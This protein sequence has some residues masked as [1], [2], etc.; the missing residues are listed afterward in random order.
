[1][2]Y[3]FILF[4]LS[5]LLISCNNKDSY[6]KEFGQFMNDTENVGEDYSD[7]E[8]AQIEIKFN[9]LYLRKFEEYKEDLTENDIKQIKKFK[10]RFTIIQV[11]REPLKNILKIIGL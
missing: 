1:M 3:L 5:V 6:I 7:Q 11:N 8:W 10:D 4:L 2:K 9:D